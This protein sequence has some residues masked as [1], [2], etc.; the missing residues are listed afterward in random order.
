MSQLNRYVRA[1]S[2]RPPAHPTELTYPCCRQ[3]LGELG[4]I[5]PHG[6]P[7]TIVRD[8]R[9]GPAG[10]QWVRGSPEQAGNLLRGG[11]A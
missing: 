7:R 8:S 1:G 11:F 6:G 4:E 2:R 9:P 5:P 3:A 10:V